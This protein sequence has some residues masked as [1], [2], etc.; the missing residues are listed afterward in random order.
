MQID[1]THCHHQAHSA[2]QPT[3]AQ[4]QVEQQQGL[5]GKEWAKREPATSCLHAGPSPGEH[6]LGQ[7]CSASASVAPAGFGHTHPQ[8]SRYGNVSYSSLNSQDSKIHG[9]KKSF[10][11][12]SLRGLV[13]AERLRTSNQVLRTNR[14]ARPVPRFPKALPLTRAIAAK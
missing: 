8:S 3:K 5:P 10:E 7:Q 11:G 9:L 6:T 12:G 13:K 14:L 4:Q 1:H 2:A